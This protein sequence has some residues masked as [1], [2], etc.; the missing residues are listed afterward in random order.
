[1]SVSSLSR[2]LRV[3]AALVVLVGSGLL[4]AAPAPAS[5]QARRTVTLRVGR[6][7]QFQQVTGQAA[8]ADRAFNRVRN[9]VWA[10]YD[11]GVFAFNTTDVRTDLYPLRG[12][13]RVNG[14]VVTFSANGSAQIGGSSA[15]TEMIGSIDF[16]SRPAVM[17][18]NWA[19]GAGY[20]AVVNNQ[21]FGSTASSAYRVRLTVVS[22]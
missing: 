10:F 12:R 9:A 3:I 16:G 19:S 17:T 22:G 11:N 20:G 15:F 5:A 8:W 7:L 4:A 21:K 1:M 18:L 6:I 13:Y 14:N 2:R